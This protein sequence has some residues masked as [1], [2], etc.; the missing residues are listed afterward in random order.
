MSLAGK[1]WRAVRHDI[2][3]KA[4]ALAL[5]VGTWFI[6]EG[7]VLADMP[8]RK[9][10][11][12]WVP[13]IEAA[14][15]DRAQSS[16]SA[17][18]LIVPDSLVFL[19]C[20]PKELTLNVKG[21]K[22]D[23]EN[24]ILSATVV[25]TEA[26]L[27]QG[28]DAG[29]IVRTLQRESFKSRGEPPELTLFQINRGSTADL[30]ISIARRTSIDMTLGPGNVQITGEPASGFVVESARAVVTPGFLPVSGPRSTIE[31]FRA[32]P[33][34]LKLAPVAVDGRSASVIRPVGLADLPDNDNVLLGAG[35][36]VTVTVPVVP[37]PKRRELRAIPVIY[38]NEAAL[39]AQGL[40]L[41]ET[42]RPS[43]FVDLI[44]EGPASELEVLSNDDLS[45]R[46]FPIYDFSNADTVEGQATKYLDV[47]TKDLSDAVKIFSLDY[48][49]EPPR[50]LIKLE[51]AAAGP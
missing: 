8:N 34:L 49:T 48:P 42:A 50:I 4:T 5:A 38:L 51:K 47:A 31:R 18:Y 16:A 33:G 3:R 2:G 26:D 17:V 15:L 13:S 9:V 27:P 39:K 44:V 12:K 24:L 29:K 20:V 25:L 1:A 46:L 22:K 43:P 32:D 41:S 23:V 36:Q 14:D 45:K 21:L 6:L 37:K 7:V 10:A 30:S 19:S 28:E 35:G 40:R 11:V